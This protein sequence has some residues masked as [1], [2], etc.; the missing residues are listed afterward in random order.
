MNLNQ[1]TIKEAKEGLKKK[2]FSSVELTRA[3]L[4]RIKKVEPKISAF[5]TVAEKQA[6]EE[7][8]KAD[9]LLAQG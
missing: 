5:V 9:A 3:C 1:L 4:E 7:A 6:L 8:K 2:E